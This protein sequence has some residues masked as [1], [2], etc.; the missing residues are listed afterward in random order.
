MIVIGRLSVQ[1]GQKPPS[2]VTALAVSLACTIATKSR[3]DLFGNSISASAVR[4]AAT[5]TAT[6]SR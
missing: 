5:S 3:T 4:G 6:V 1:N 2:H